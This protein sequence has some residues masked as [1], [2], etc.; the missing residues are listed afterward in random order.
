MR[1][2]QAWLVCIVAA[3]VS[4]PAQGQDYPAKPVIFITPAAAG[5][6]PDVAT[7]IVAE[8]LTQVWKG[9]RA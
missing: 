3:V 9:P 7:R 1:I 4:L 2:L 6:S 5:N 8:H